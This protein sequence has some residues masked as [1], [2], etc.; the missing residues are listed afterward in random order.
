MA[1]TA[2]GAGL[3]LADNLIKLFAPTISQEQQ[4]SLLDA[5]KKRSNEIGYVIQMVANAPLGQPLPELHAL[6]DQ[7]CNAAGVPSADIGANV[8]ISLDRLKCLLVIA[9]TLV[10]VTEQAQVKS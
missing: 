4:E 6:C 3:D 2:I 7:L 5:Y 8:S 1:V 10:L 9:N